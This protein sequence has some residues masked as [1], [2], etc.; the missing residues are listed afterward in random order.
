MSS[1]WAP[2]TTK[3]TADSFR[4]PA[5]ACSARTGS[6]FQQSFASLENSLSGTTNTWSLLATDTYT[7]LPSLNLI[8]SGRYNNTTVKTTDRINPVPP[9]LDGDF[10]YTKFNPA[11]GITY[12][13]FE[14]LNVFGGWSQGNRVPTPIELGCA[15]PANPCTL[16]AGLA[17]DP[18]LNQV[19]AQTWEIGA[20]GMIVNNIRWNA[21]LF[22]TNNTNDILFVG[23]TTSAGFFT[24]YGRTRRQGLEIGFSGNHSRFNWAFNYSYINATFQS[25]ACLLSENNSSRGTS[26][27]CTDPATGTGDD[28][29]RVSSGDQ[30]PGI[31]QNQ[32]RMT[33]EYRVLDN[34]WIGGTI[35]AFSDQY[36]RGNENNQHAAGTYTD[37]LGN[38][39]TFTGPGTAGGYAVVNLTTRFRPD[40]RWEIFARVNNLF[41]R[42]YSTAGALAEN[43]FNANGVFLTNSDDWSRDTFYAPGAPFGIWVGVRFL[44]DR[45]A[46]Q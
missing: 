32:F 15:D 14:T 39:R 18:F 10:N 6:V 27:A 26:P 17:S 37:L 24:N 19:V 21:A 33:G 29:I 38:T 1:K 22:Q 34:W 2:R 43:P 42:K 30:I 40:P 35:L 44:L 20:R 36:V 16:P 8:V 9:N 13:P 46:A 25:S 23:T 5:W 3:A 41:D 28:L 12:S 4:L 7:I 45:P 11:G 31:P